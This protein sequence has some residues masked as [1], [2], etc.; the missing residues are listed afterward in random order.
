[1][2][3]QNKIALITGGATGIGKAAAQRLLAEGARVVI[4]AR[5]E[6]RLR[7]TQAE[8]D[9]TGERLAIVAGDIGQQDTAASSRPPSTASEAWTSS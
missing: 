5:T 8:L 2:E 3:F 9:P 7:E 1:M 4:N 6:E